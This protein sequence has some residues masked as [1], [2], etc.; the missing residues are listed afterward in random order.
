MSWR[1]FR[2]LF[3]ALEADM[4]DIDS[5]VCECGRPHPSI[6]R[7][8][9]RIGRRLHEL[10]GRMA[11][12][13]T[14]VNDTNRKVIE[15][16]VSTDKLL[17]DVQTLVDGSKAKD[18]LIA[19]LQAELANAD[20]SAQARVDAAVAAEDSDAQAKID[21]ADQVVADFNNP[22]APPAPAGD[23]SAP[24]DGSGDVPTSG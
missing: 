5:T 13:E 20:A 8:L 15:V 16:A 14:T 7:A 6:S 9:A 19:Q 22:P 4:T 18:L 2:A 23:G 24:S 17:S 3:P 21:A 1:V 11:A 12:V 10:D